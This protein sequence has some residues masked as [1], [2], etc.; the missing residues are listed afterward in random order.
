MGL[1]K[2]K[3]VRGIPCNYFRITNIAMDMMCKNTTISLA[4]YF[5]HQARLDDQQ[6]ILDYLTL[7][8]EGI[9]YSDETA[10]RKLKE[11]KIG[12]DLSAEGN[13]I[14]VQKNWFFDAQDV[15]EPGQQ[16]TA[17]IIEVKKSTGKTNKKVK[18]K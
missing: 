4:I 8:F 6:N 13:L 15:F 16:R 10:Y 2:Q 7:I 17:P 9:N 1:C 3:I 5:S 12:H 18:I 14:E 11:S